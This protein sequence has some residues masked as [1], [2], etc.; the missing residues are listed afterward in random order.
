MLLEALQDVP[1]SVSA[2]RKG[3][4]FR[5]PD[6]DRARDY[7]KSGLARAPLI[8]AGNGSD[9]L[10]WPGATVVILASGPSLSV[11]QCDAVKVWRD[12]DASRHVITVNTSF[13][14]APWADV[15]Y[16]C[17][18]EWWNLYHEEVE[19]SATGE[20]W[21]QDVDAA[22]KY[23][24]K[25]MKSAR[26]K[27]LSLA[28]GLIN[29]GE[30][31]GYQSIGLCWQAKAAKVYLLGFDNHGDHWHGKHPSPL[32]KINPYARWAGNYDQMAKDC[33]AAGLEVINCTPKS[34]LRTFP[35][36]DWREVFGC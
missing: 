34:A 11:E 33:K 13:R 25:L 35:A 10:S 22:A 16:A 32:N 30:S 1:S 20:R 36:M 26:G 9:V 12:I 21:T 8:K 6:P 17:D 28:P 2:I 5:E 24:L 23:G 7:I 15:V 18:G 3:D 31:S 19:I 4:V 29:Q 27:G 14:R